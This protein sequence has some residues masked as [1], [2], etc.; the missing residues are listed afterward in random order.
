LFFIKLSQSH[1]S[2][3]RIFERLTWVIRTGRMELEYFCQNLGGISEINQDSSKIKSILICFI[4]IFILKWNRIPDIY[5]N[6][7]KLTSRY[8]TSRQYFGNKVV[9]S[10][11]GI[12]KNSLV[13]FWNLRLGREACDKDRHLF[14]KTQLEIKR[15]ERK[16]LHSFLAKK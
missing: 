10:S 16:L 15:K 3:C 8:V 2:G 12:R 5:K 4:F 1:N 11:L 13:Q 9:Q 7:K 6:K 14:D